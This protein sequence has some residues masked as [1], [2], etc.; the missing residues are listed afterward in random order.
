[1]VSPERPSSSVR[2]LGS[3]LRFGA[4]VVVLSAFA[5][6]WGYLAQWTR[7]DC[8]GATCTF[9]GRRLL[10][11]P[12]ATS[13][14]VSRK[15]L[16]EHPERIELRIVD[17]NRGTSQVHVHFEPGDGDGKGE[18]SGLVYEGWRS[19]T[20]AKLDELRRAAAS[21]AAPVHESVS[22]HPFGFV[23]LGFVGV[24]L[25]VLVVTRLRGRAKR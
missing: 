8:A 9:E 15:V 16:A 18:T 4:A 21:D 13:R 24:A 17:A 14:T 11:F 5:L 10:T 7:F 6:L 25:I 23:A 2:S 3:T 1:L 12:V 19:E 20:A 22:P